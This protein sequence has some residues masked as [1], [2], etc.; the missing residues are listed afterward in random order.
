MNCTGF[1]SLY[2]ESCDNPKYNYLEVAIKNNDSASA[3]TVY[4]FKANPIDNNGLVVNQGRIAI[5]CIQSLEVVNGA[6]LKI[7]GCQ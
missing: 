5:G 7:K 2:G 6:V 4:V 1:C 3:Y